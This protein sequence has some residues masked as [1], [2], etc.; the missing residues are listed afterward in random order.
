MR[1]P[2]H[3]RNRGAVTNPKALSFRLVILERSDTEWNST[4]G[5]SAMSLSPRRSNYVI[6]AFPG[7]REAVADLSV[8]VLLDAN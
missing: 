1:R 5:D 4:S 3:R 2:R 7:V 6:A 8:Q